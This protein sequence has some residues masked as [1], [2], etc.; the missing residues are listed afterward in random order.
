MPLFDDL[1]M[2][3][4]P[5]PGL[6]ATC[7]KEEVF[8]DYQSIGLSL[9][10]HPLSFYRNTLEGMEVRPADQL[11]QLANNQPVSVAGLV[12]LRQRPST[13]KGIT[14]VTLE[15]ETGIA[16]LVVH[17]DIWQRYHTVTRHAPAWIAHGHIERQGAVIHVVVRS[18]EPLSQRLRELNARARDFR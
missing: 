17:Q 18:V 14:F 11:P 2:D 12:L 13:A 3:Q 9:R 15:D 7:D 16:N 5:P 1:A 6:P 10:N 8:A 4:S